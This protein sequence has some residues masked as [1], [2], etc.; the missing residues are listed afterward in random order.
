[1]DRVVFQEP[2][3]VGDIVSLYARTV[4]KGRTSVT[5]QVEVEAER[6]EDLKT[7]RVTEAE[8]VFVAVDDQC[9]PVP[10]HENK[11]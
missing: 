6:L 7:V 9:R 2:V 5:I 11:A 8:V 3:F 10:L 1:M 4:K